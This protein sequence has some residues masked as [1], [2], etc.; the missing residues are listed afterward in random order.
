M[1]DP[2]FNGISAAIIGM[3]KRKPVV[4]DIQDM[5]PDMAI[6]ASIVA[7]GVI[8]AILGASPSLGT[9][10]RRPHHRPRR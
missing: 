10:P 3:L 4:Y 2:P 6:A 5:Y 9:A 1:T 7:P 8:S